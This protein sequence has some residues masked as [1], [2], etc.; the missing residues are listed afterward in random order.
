[1][2]LIWP[3]QKHQFKEQMKELIYLTFWKRRGLVETKYLGNRI[4]YKWITVDTCGAESDGWKTGMGDLTVSVNPF[5]LLEFCAL[6]MYYLF[7]K[8]I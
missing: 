7:E 6:C 3:I 8:A 5:A 4:S 2:T 1:M